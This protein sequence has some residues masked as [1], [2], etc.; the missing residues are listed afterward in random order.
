MHH[1][2]NVVYLEIKTPKGKVSDNQVDFQRQCAEDGITYLVIRSME[3]LES[4]FNTG[5]R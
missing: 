4:Y 1:D 2:G 3:D 5:K